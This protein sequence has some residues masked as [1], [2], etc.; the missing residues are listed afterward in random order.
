MRCRLGEA[1]QLYE[2]EVVPAKAGEGQR[3][4]T[5]RAFYAGAISLLDIYTHDVSDGEELTESDEAVMRDLG[6]EVQEF[7]H[8][9]ELERLG[10]KKMRGSKR[11]SSS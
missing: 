3:Q 11:E 5:R 1:W 4:D 9:T 7:L 10:I 6:R 2:R 8:E